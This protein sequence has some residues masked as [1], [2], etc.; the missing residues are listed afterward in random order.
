MRY[1]EYNNSGDIIRTGMCAASVIKK[2]KK[3]GLNIIEGEADDINYKIVDGKIEKK[4][5]EEIK[6]P[7]KPNFVR[8]ER[9]YLTKKIYDD[10]IKRI[11]TLEKG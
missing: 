6:K 2:K 4:K 11:E 10:L 8:E 9:I 5:P 1:I 3:D 7:P